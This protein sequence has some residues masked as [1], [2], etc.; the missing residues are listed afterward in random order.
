VKPEPEDNALEA[1][2]K[3]LLDE[4]SIAGKIPPAGRKT[5]AA[6]IRAAGGGRLTQEGLAW[7]RQH[8]AEMSPVVTTEATRPRPPIPTDFAEQAARADGL[9][10]FPA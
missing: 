4:A 6:K 7:G 2:L 9:E 8:I 1:E 3:T 10:Q 5:F